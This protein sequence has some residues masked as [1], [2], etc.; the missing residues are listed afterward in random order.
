MAK[1][2]FTMSE[3]RCALEENGFRKVITHQNSGNVILESDF[4][5]KQKL[6]QK[7]SKIIKEKFQLEIPHF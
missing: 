4:S 2:K 3:L 6:S 1:T 5:S 7:V